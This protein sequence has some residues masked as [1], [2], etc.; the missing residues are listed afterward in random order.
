[1]A[2]WNHNGLS[3]ATSDVGVDAL[4]SDVSPKFSDVGYVLEYTKP[5]SSIYDF[6]MNGINYFVF[7]TDIDTN[8]DQYLNAPFV[9]ISGVAWNQEKLDP[10]ASHIVNQD[11]TT[12]YNANRIYG[13]PVVLFNSTALSDPSGI[14]TAITKYVSFSHVNN[15]LVSYLDH[16]Y[17]QDEEMLYVTY[18]VSFN[19]PSFNI[20]TEFRAKIRLSN[21]VYDPSAPIGISTFGSPPVPAGGTLGATDIPIASSEVEVQRDFDFIEIKYQDGVNFVYLKTPITREEWFSTSSQIISDIISAKNLYPLNSIIDIVSLGTFDLTATESVNNIQFLIT[22]EEFSSKA[23]DVGI[24]DFTYHDGASAIQSHAMTPA[25]RLDLAPNQGYKLFIRVIA[26]DP[27]GIAYKF[28]H[29]LHIL[30]YD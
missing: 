11:G 9:D 8:P 29:G 18:K 24:R 21:F 6:N 13:I 22:S 25:L 27:F 30:F 20:D 15:L 7:G 12:P 3:I 14:G 26:D 28:N 1:M 2:I 4:T 5:A 17:D 16:L 10:S 19:E 23:A